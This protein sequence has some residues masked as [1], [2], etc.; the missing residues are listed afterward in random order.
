MYSSNDKLPPIHS[1]ATM[2]NTI[3]S[4]TN[5]NNSNTKNNSIQS[6]IKSSKAAAAPQKPAI[7]SY[8][9]TNASDPALPPHH[10]YHRW[11]GNLAQ[12][13]QELDLH[14]SGGPTRVVMSKFLRL[15]YRD[16]ASIL[17]STTAPPEMHKGP[18]RL[19][20]K[21]A[22]KMFDEKM[23]KLETKLQKYKQERK[24]LMKQVKFSSIKLKEIERFVSASGNTTNRTHPLQAG[25]EYNNTLLSS[26]MHQEAT[27]IIAAAAPSTSGN[28][29]SNPMTMSMAGTNALPRLNHARRS[30]QW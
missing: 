18:K 21:E 6:A 20:A 26:P 30:M 2:N 27:R 16:D 11:K 4:K 15:L 23:T 28:N 17:T 19:T 25:S 29:N 12:K 13:W 10:K 24:Q 9:D 22:N 8:D 5:N 3:A 7:A 1:K 14:Y